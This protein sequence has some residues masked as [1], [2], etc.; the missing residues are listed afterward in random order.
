VDDIVYNDVW[1]MRNYFVDRF[2]ENKYT[3]GIFTKLNTCACDLISEYCECVCILYYCMEHGT[4]Q[5]CKNVKGI[6]G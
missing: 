5:E 2:M 4:R 6:A 1:C 3:T